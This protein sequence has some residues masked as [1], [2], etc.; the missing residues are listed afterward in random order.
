MKTVSNKLYKFNELSNEAK[1]NARAWC[2]RFYEGDDLFIDS[3]LTKNKFYFD[4]NGKRIDNEYK[5]CRVFTIDGSDAFRVWRGH[6]TIAEFF[7]E[8][9]EKHANMFVTELLKQK[10]E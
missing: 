6:D 10:M 2:R 5:I 8:D 9:S 3:I 4:K 7:G 1:K